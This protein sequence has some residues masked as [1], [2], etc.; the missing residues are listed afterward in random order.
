MPQFRG[1][2]SGATVNFPSTRA[3]RGV[4]PHPVTTLGIAL[5]LLRPVPA[6]ARDLPAGQACQRL[7][8]TLATEGRVALEG[9]EF[10]F[11][12]AAGPSAAPCR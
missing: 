7:V 1:H 8:E 12:R 3:C 10:G 9:V 2:S 4:F 11:N 6:Q 5:A